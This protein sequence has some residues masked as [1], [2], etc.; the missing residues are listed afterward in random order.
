MTTSE[1]RPGRSSLAPADYIAETKR[2]YDS[3]GYDSYR[4]ASRPGTPPW[5][6]IDKPLSQCR[7]TLVG[8][9]GI[10]R[11]GQVAFHTKD[12]TSVRVIPTNTPTKDLRTAHFAYDQTD[13]RTDPNCVFPLDRL[14][15]MEADGEIGGLTNNAFAFMGGIYSTRRLEAETAP[16]LV[17]QCKAEEPD[18]VLLVPV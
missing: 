16:L 11:H 6:P 5:S 13:A 9:G 15:E 3:L 8:S 18:L 14:T 1:L 17:E 2:L 10:Y 4:W 12:D 7:I